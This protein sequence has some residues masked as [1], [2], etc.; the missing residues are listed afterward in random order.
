MKIIDV[1]SFIESLGVKIPPQE[2]FFQFADR[3]GAMHVNLAGEIERHVYVRGLLLYSLIAKHKPKT[4][5]EFGTAG[6]YSALCMAWAMT[7][8]DIDGTIYTV[9]RF[10]QN[11]PIRRII[12]RG[13]GKPETIF[14]SNKEYWP[15]VAPISWISKIKP[16]TGHSGQIMAKTKFPKIEFSYIDAAHHYEAVK[17]DFYS[18]FDVASENFSVLLDDY[19]E[20]PFYGITRFVDDEIKDNFDTYLIETDMVNINANNKKRHGMIWAHS[21]TAKKP[22][23]ELFPE[24]KV[25]TY[26]KSYRRYERFITAPRHM[27]NEKIPSLKKIRFKF[28]KK[29]T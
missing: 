16:L 9:D 26:L 10:P 23:S 14:Q 19:I 13:D 8:H 15:K 11:K 20:R 12:D 21:S 25:F 6:G 3:L 22:I 2:K 5:L 1:N 29:M 4:I 17:H 18:F 28:W 24:N 7:D 27:M